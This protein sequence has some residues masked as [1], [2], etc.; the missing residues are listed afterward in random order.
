M[1]NHL[2]VRYPFPPLYPI[3][4]GVSGG[5][6]GAPALS[7][8]IG[9]I[10]LGLVCALSAVWVR[11]VGGSAIAVLF[12]PVIFTLMPA[13]LIHAMGIFSEP[14][15]LIFLLAGLIIVPR[16]NMRGGHWMLAGALLGC[17]AITRS[18]GLFAVASFVIVWAWRTRGKHARLAVLPALLIPGAWSAF[19]WAAGWQGSYMAPFDGAGMLTLI[20][21]QLP[22]NLE[23]LSYHT[24]RL[25]DLLGSDYAAITLSLLLIPMTT[26]L[27]KRTAQPGARCAIRYDLHCSDRVLAISE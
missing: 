15:Y 23:A 9:G 14:L 22:H 6:L 16:D 25:F 5:G 3:V 19:K 26:T 12:V 18:V 11:R 8:W 17:A 7:Y 13:T 10:S 20:I 1:V 24:L 27:I 4:L 2:V 21:E